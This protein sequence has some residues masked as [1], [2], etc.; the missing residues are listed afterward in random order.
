MNEEKHFKVGD[1]IKVSN[2]YHWAKNATGEISE[3]PFEF[4]EENWIENFY[5]DV[6]T[7][8]GKIRFYWVKFDRSQFNAD[9][10][11]LFWGGE[12]ESEYLEPIDLQF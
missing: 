8:K 4:E 7:L 3:Y 6:E 1:R 11:G 10:E 2:N 12:I 5:R 9:R